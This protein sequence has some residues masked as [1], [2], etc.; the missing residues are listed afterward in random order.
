MR[1][2][3]LSFELERVKQMHF[4]PAILSH[5]D[6]YKILTGS[7]LPRPIAWVSTLDENG[8]S[9]L[10]PFSFFMGVCSRPLTVAFSPMQKPT[11]ETKD[12]VRNIRLNKEFVINVVPEILAKRMNQTSANYARGVS[13]FESAGLTEAPSVIVK[14]SRVLESPIAMECKLHTMVEMGEGPGSGTLIVGVVVQFHCDNDLI[15]SDYHI[16][17]KKLKLVGRLSGPNYVRTTGDIFELPRPTEP[18]KK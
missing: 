3:R 7:V 13:E 12:T 14:P 8:I 11:G 1:V 9:N 18:N 17:L 4:D 6:A 5:Q 10:A 16:D 15:T 2:G